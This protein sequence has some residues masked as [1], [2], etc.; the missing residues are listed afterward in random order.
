VP[1]GADPVELWTVCVTNASG[2]PREVSLFTYGAVSLRGALTHGYIHFCQGRYVPE[3]GGLFFQNN[4]PNLPHARYKAFQACDAKCD[5]YDASAGSFRGL[6]GTLV[7]PAAVAAG[8]CNDAQAGRE[9]MAACFH[10][11]LRLAPG[12]TATIHFL[13]G[14][15]ASQ[16]EAEQFVRRY[17]D[18][19]GPGRVRRAVADAAERLLESP[20]IATPSE[21]VNRLIGV[22]AKRQVALGAAW[23]RWGWRGYRDI[24]QQTHGACYF[25]LPRVRANL[26][27]AMTWQMRDGFAVRGWA[28]LSPRRYA[29]SALWLCYAV[30][31]YVKETG[32]GDFVHKPLPYRDGDFGPVWEHL[33]RACGKVRTDA[34][35][36]GLPR[37]HQGDWNDSLS[38]VGEAGRGESVWLAEALCWALLELGELFEAAGLDEQAGT[39]A[40]WHAEMAERINACAWDG[41]WYV[42]GFCD[43]GTPLGSHT[44]AE[45]R[46]Y[47]NAQSWAIL[48]RVA[49]P[50]RRAAMLQAVEK[51]LRVRYGYLTLSPPYTSFDSRIG[52]ITGMP[53]G[54][55]ENSAVYVHANAFFYAALLAIGAADRALELLETL[56]PCNAI[57]PTGNSGAAPYVLP[58]S[59]YGP[60]YRVPG[61]IEGTWV[62]GSASWFLHQTVEHLCGVRRTH[63]G[64]RIAPNLPA[65]WDGARV[66][67]RFRGDGYDVTIRRREGAGPVRVELDG[68]AIDGDLLPIPGD[69][70]THE[71][72]ATVGK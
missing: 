40:Q 29:D 7:A 21:P 1:P 10:K 5:S 13:A 62:T 63:G 60:S 55:G 39:A 18:G 70:K 11:K 19:G 24:V 22:W 6:Y 9:Q 14:I 53:P 4:A 15:V 38:A 48:G 68:A 34:G 33:L 36:H 46:I 67:R 12:E 31:D 51:H 2:R 47:L 16:D 17:L 64:L 50:D 65:A 37:I 54:T 49:P 8:R 44:Q 59:Y 56:H 30:N 66:R 3:L 43:D 35:P 52:R 69:G 57:N 72:R 26:C 41:A 25:D 71:V 42:R 61:R 58:S 32:D 27:E 45:G 20:A 28:P 23:G